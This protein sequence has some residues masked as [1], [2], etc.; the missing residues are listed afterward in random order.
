MLPKADWFLLSLKDYNSANGLS[1]FARKH[2]Q[3][4]GG[5]A[6]LLI[7]GVTRSLFFEKLLPWVAATLGVREANHGATLQSANI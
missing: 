7:L 4:K 6:V 1:S 2:G 3:L 5:R